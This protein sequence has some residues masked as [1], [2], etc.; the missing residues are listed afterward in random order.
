M[1]W[2]EDLTP[3]FMDVAKDEKGLV[4][5]D[6]GYQYEPEY[7]NHLIRIKFDRNEQRVLDSLLIEF[8][9]Q[10]HMYIGNDEM[11]TMEKGNI[12]KAIEISR[13]FAD[14][15]TESKEV[16]E[17]FIHQLENAVMYDSEVFFE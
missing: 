13:K 17:K 10:F 5:I 7:E 3:M 16:Y 4:G 2:I 15:A 6:Y 11:S 9:T 12:K 8:M 1:E 14:E